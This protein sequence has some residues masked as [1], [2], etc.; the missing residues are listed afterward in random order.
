VEKLPAEHGL[1]AETML[2][3]AA[4]GAVR[5]FV[6]GGVEPADFRHPEAV[7]R[8]LEEADFV[9]SL[10]TRLSQ[11]TERADVV[12]PVSVIEERSG[13]FV[14]LEG[15]ER[16]VTKYLGA[17]HVMSD[18]RV[19]AA[20]ADAMGIPLGVRTAAEAKAE[21]DE[22]G[23]WDGARARAPKH[24]PAQA[25]ELGAGEAI[26]ATWRELI[27]DSR[28]ADGEVAL[29]A[30]ARRPVVR[31][32]EAMANGLPEGTMVKISRPG[33]GEIVLPLAVTPAMIDGVIWV[34]TAAPGVRVSTT[35]GAVAG[36][37]VRVAL[38]EG[39]VTQPPLK[40]AGEGKQ[41]D[42]SEGAGS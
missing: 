27:D 1:D 28:G 2:A 14:N 8:G 16:L 25:V 34:P 41:Q 37:V 30:T 13:T 11:V 22:L 36:D 12:F 19:L 15:R 32:N 29:L 31:M 24:A 23:R 35:L 6:V 3:A 4:D 40:P 21:I 42:L 33:S 39:G 5:A 18:L 38:A 7:L 10:E 26:L 9:I 17:E 20:L